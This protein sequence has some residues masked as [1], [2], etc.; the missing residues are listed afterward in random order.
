MRQPAQHPAR[1]PAALE[2]GQAARPPQV[3]KAGSTSSP[4]DQRRNTPLAWAAHLQGAVHTLLSVLFQG[5]PRH[6]HALHCQKTNPPPAIA[7][8]RIACMSLPLMLTPYVSSGVINHPRCQLAWIALPAIHASPTTRTV[9]YTVKV[10]ARAAGRDS[11]ACPRPGPGREGQ[12]ARIPY[13]AA[14]MHQLRCCCTKLALGPG[15][16]SWVLAGRATGTP[17]CPPSS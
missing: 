7:L 9:Q 17:A 11:R 5:N 14:H 6:C 16:G 10:L 4:S 13:F 12:E 1:E 8:A 2:A 15:V 3:H